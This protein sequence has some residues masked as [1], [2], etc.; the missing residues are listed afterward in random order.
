MYDLILRETKFQSNWT[1]QSN[2]GYNCSYMVLFIS[3]VQMVHWINWLLTLDSYAIYLIVC[4]TGFA[5]SVYE[6]VCTV[7]YQHLSSLFC[8]N[9][10]PGA[11]DY[12]CKNICQ[13]KLFPQNDPNWVLIF[14]LVF[15][16][17][18]WVHAVLYVCCTVK[19]PARGTGDSCQDLSYQ[20]VTQLKESVLICKESTESELNIQGLT[21]CA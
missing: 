4:F 20:D 11:N 21:S 5:V 3:K 2:I 16:A 12:V 19:Y 7:L 14:R 8:E 10:E 1:V 18:Q 6:I 13:F 17:V 15:F 9:L